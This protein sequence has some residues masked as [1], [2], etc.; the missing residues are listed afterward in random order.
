MTLPNAI[1]QLSK[2]QNVSMSPIKQNVVSA[3]RMDLFPI[4]DDPNWIRVGCFIVFV[5]QTIQRIITV[6]VGYLIIII[7]SHLVF[8]MYNINVAPVLTYQFNS[9]GIW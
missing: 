6:I 5:A 1:K 3:I 8:E 4:M 9:R 2:L 7:I